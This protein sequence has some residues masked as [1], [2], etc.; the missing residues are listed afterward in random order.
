MFTIR[1]AKKSS[2]LASKV[3][4]EGFPESLS[5]KPYLS[6]FRQPKAFPQTRNTRTF[7][8][9]NYLHPLD[10]VRQNESRN[11]KTLDGSP[12]FSDSNMVETNNLPKSEFHGEKLPAVRSPYTVHKAIRRSP[13]PSLNQSEIILSSYFQENSDY[14]PQISPHK[15]NK[16]QIGNPDISM[17]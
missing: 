15:R 12:L 3:I 5:K 8:N 17:L 7:R 14:S 4:S 13:K 1:L 6:G 2:M 10:A 16:S 9:K 11:D